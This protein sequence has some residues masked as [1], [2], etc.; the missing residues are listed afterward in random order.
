[1]GLLGSLFVARALLLRV[2]SERGLRSERTGV[3]SD[4]R[5]PVSETALGILAASWGVIMALSPV[6]Q[7]RRMVRLQS[8]RDVSIGYLLVIVVG[9]T[10]WFSY[11]IAIR[12]AAIIVANGLAFLVGMATVA[13][14]L[15]FRMRDAESGGRKPAHDRSS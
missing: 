6:M 12:N 13:V 8:S 9:F 1:M 2:R 3:G 15:R 4:R 11:G 7:I 5:C 10:V 14:A